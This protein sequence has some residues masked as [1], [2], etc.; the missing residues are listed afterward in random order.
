ME[1]AW[2]APNSST[3]SCRPPLRSSSTLCCLCAP[4]GRC[5]SPR[6]PSIEWCRMQ[7]EPKISSKATPTTSR[8]RTETRIEWSALQTRAIQMVPLGN[9]TIYTLNATDTLIVYI[10]LQ[11]YSSRP[12]LFPSRRH[13]S[14]FLVSC[15]TCDYSSWWAFH[16]SWKPY[17]FSPIPTAAST[18]YPMW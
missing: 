13:R 5:I 14:S 7:P 12:P 4:Y 9:G 2:K 16:G 11:Y 10:T 17:H 6:R 15:S 1:T 18:G 8:L 3:F